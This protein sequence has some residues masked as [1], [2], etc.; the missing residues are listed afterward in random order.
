MLKRGFDILASGI[1]LILL[2]PLLLILMVLV[3]LD[4]AGTSFLPS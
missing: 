2:T 3:K 4:S 1:G